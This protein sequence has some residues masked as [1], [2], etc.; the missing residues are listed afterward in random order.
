MKLK[1]GLIVSSQALDGNPLKNSESLAVMA[2]AAA[3]G[4]AVAIRANGFLNIMAMRK[5]FDIPIIGINKFQDKEG[6]TII[7]PTF[8]S[9]AEVARAGCD[10]IAMDCTFRKSEIREDPAEII[11]KIHSELGLEVMA[12]ISNLDEAL[13][14]EKIGADYISTTLAGYTKDR[15]YLPHEKYTPNFALIK[16]ILECGVKIPVIAEGRF[17]RPEDL[18]FALKM[19]VHAIVIGKSI[20]NPMAITE[21]FCKTVNETLS[22]DG[23]IKTETRN[24]KTLD[25]DK[26]STFE[27]LQKIN[28]EDALVAN[29]VRDKLP[30]IAK[31]VDAILPGF[32]QDGRI[33]YCGAGT[34]ARLAVADAAE[35]PPT[36]GVD[37]GKIVASVAGG[38]DAVFSAKENMEDSYEAGERAA[39]ALCP[40]PRDT[41]IGVSAN[42]NAQFAIGFLTYAKKMG[43]KTV[44]IVNNLN[45]KIGDLADYKIELLTGAECIQGSTRM[46]AGSSQKMTLNMLSTALFVKS[47]YVKSNLMVNVKPTNVKL[48]ARCIFILKSLTEKDEAECEALLEK[49]NWKITAVLEELGI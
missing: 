20:T 8:E 39:A 11:K 18:A 4:G 40:T 33:L 10:V 17:W 3:K 12:D 38:R 30:E 21:Y 2:E 47:G 44:G 45:T 22:G 7:T 32:K 31:I 34:S 43:A 29:I 37:E 1:R 46:K 23:W 48:R 5:R 16:E 9:A 6:T 36:Y 26:V 25:I 27:V 41:A 49:H 13:Y 14:A 35:C 19:G 24:P 28:A 42:G 15:P